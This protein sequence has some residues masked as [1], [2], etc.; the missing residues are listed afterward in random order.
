MLRTP[1]RIE[2][3]LQQQ[4]LLLLSLLLLLLLEVSLCAGET[5]WTAPPRRG[6]TTAMPAVD[7]H[8]HVHHWPPLLAP[9]R[10]PKPQPATA[11]DGPIESFDQRAL[12]GEHEY[13]YRLSNGDTR[14]ER[15]YWL[16]LGSGRTVLA[17]RGYYSVPLPNAQYSTVFY[18][19]DDRGYHVDM[20]TLSGEQ[21]LLPR[22]L[23]VP[24]DVAG[25]QSTP[26]AKRNSISVPERNDEQLEQHPDAPAMASSS[27]SNSSSSS[28]TAK[29]QT[30]A[31]VRLPAVSQSQS[32]SQ[33]RTKP[34]TMATLED[35]FAAKVGTASADDDDDDNDDDD[36][37]H[38]D[39]GVA[40]SNINAN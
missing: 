33:N 32:R 16:H 40:A 19:A 30:V 6:S 2:M 23:D 24:H 11:I 3:C 37:G 25:M 31:N 4:L 35:I 27:S 17:R 1:K 20:H 8:Q 21:P 36:E 7:R 10:E 15:T 14:Y 29:G 12:S 13:R 28:G 38:K 9:Q 5:R 26:A 39:D 34:S 22:S 18:S